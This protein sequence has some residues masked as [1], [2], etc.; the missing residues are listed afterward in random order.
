MP[1]A[2]TDI[3]SNRNDQIVHAVTVLKGSVRRRRVFDAI[4]RGKKKAKTVEELMAAT[5]YSQVVVLQMGGEL[6]SQQLV[7]QTKINRHSDLVWR[8]RR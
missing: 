4:Y 5:G 6:D 1:T 3:R 2:V 7:T 8:N